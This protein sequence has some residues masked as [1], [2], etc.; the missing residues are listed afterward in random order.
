MARARISATSPKN[1]W[2]KSQI[3]SA[4]LSSRSDVVTHLIRK[5]RNEEEEIATICLALS[6]GM[7]SG[8]SNEWH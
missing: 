4:E 7:E 6:R 1:A 2:I 3:Q 8:V 5:A